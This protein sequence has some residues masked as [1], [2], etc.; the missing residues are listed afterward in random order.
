[1]SGNEEDKKSFWEEFF[2][3]AE[4]E[5]PP[6]KEEGTRLPVRNEDEDLMNILEG[7]RQKVESF[8]E[9][10]VYSPVETQED[11]G[12]SSFPEDIQKE[13]EEVPLPIKEEDGDF[14]ELR[15]DAREEDAPKE[16]LDIFPE[17]TQEGKEGVRLPVKEGD[18]YSEDLP[19]EESEEENLMQDGAGN[20][21]EAPAGQYFYIHNG[22]TLKNLYDLEYYLGTMTDNQFS[23]HTTDGRND[24]ASWVRDVLREGELA[25]ELEGTRERKEMYDILARFL[26]LK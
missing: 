15:E 20:L 25:S 2:G 22:P 5:V 7:K 24:F 3:V 8:E 9:E 12:P 10:S 26:T 19:G 6:Q 14:E 18:E 17:D 1:M 16:K 23:Y 4:D 11:E 21:Y 13:E